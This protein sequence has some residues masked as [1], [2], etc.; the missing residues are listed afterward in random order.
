VVDADWRLRFIEPPLEALG[1]QRG[2]AAGISVL[3]RVH[4]AD[5]PSLLAAA[6]LVRSGRT[7]RS[8]VRARYRVLNPEPGYLNTECEITRS[9]SLP[10]GWLSLTNRL[11]GA[12]GDDRPVAHR[13]RDITH[14]ALA[15]EEGPL[16]TSGRGERT[17]DL[18]AARFGLTEREAEILAL[19]VDGY[20]VSTIARAL[21]LSDG[22]VRNYLSAIFRKV[23]VRS[24]AELLEHLRGA[25]DR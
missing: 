12:P 15:E 20:R 7:A 21:H 14:A 6:D 11:Q 24:Q 8:L 1:V 10:D 17:A 5:V 4:P 19:L 22:T 9:P 23:G 16:P 3:P 13:L 25:A 18:A 2:L